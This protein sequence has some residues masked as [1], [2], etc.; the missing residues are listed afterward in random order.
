M[1]KPQGKWG[2]NLYKFLSTSL[3]CSY[4]DNYECPEN[5]K[6]YK[7]AVIYFGANKVLKT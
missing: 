4:G 5:N 1:T 3:H 6:K 2:S 7:N